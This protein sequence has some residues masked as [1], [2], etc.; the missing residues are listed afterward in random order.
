[1]IYKPR[2]LCRVTVP[3]LL[4][5]FPLLSWASP[6]TAAIRAIVDKTIAPLM[7]EYK[8]PGMAVG[9]IIGERREVFNYGV[10]SREANTPVDDATLFEVGSVSKTV[11]ATLVAYAQTQGKLSLS[12]HPSKY[13][14]ALKGSAIDKATLLHLGTYTAGGLPMQFP[15]GVSDPEPADYY[16]NWKPV[17]AP[18]TMREYSNPSLG[19]FGYMAARALHAEFADVVQTTLFPQLGMKSSYVDVPPAAMHN[20]AWGYRDGKAMRANPDPFSAATYG[21]KTTASDLLHFVE[22]NMAPELVDKPMRSAVEGTHIGYFKIGPM[23][24]GLGWEQYAY[25]LSLQTLLEGNSEQM[26]WE[27][28]PAGR[29]SSPHIA[30]DSTLFNKTGSTNGFG[31]Y[32]AF[33][34]KA[35]VGVVILANVNY[36]IP[37]RVKAAYAIIEQLSKMPRTSDTGQP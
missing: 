28:N 30:G 13:W 26:L 35:K 5:S 24:Q 22:V 37:E 10:A 12:D 25:P 15:E 14:P 33:V 7:A 16:R 29:I 31:A 9:V 11:T 20:Y 4:A 36:P 21:V 18:G 32:V 3:M 2:F 34:P 19:L 1:L 17:A 27:R 8:V 6:D 23:V